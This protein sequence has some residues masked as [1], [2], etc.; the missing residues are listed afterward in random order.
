MTEGI[1]LDE[2]GPPT[3]EFAAKLSDI[4][5]IVSAAG[6][7]LDQVV[8]V[9]TGCDGCDADI[10]LDWTKNWPGGMK[11]SDDEKLLAPEEVARLRAEADAERAEREAEAE[12]RAAEA[13]R[14]A[15]DP[16]EGW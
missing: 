15:A 6:V 1:D 14:V 12:A 4:V 10:Y 5:R 3:F 9:G 13:E 8:I 11:L 16:L 2:C 7:A